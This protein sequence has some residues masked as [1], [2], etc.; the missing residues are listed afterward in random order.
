LFWQ[1][2]TTIYETQTSLK[3]QIAE[4]MQKEKMYERLKK[5]GDASSEFAKNFLQRLWRIA[6][7]LEPFM[8]DT[9]DSIKRTIKIN[10]KP[11]S[12]FLRK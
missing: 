5:E 4:L 2:F 11:E 3:Q 7:M 6:V 12:L 9:S 1:E 8:P 10:K